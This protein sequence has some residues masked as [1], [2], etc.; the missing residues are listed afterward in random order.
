[1]RRGNCIMYALRC[2]GG[3][4]HVGLREDMWKLRVSYQPDLLRPHVRYAYVPLKPW[5]APWR[6]FHW[7]FKGEV[8]RVR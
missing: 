3:V 7:W 6:L 2:Q 4:M 5:P 1:M 8:R